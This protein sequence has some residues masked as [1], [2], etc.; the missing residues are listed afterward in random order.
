MKVINDRY[1]IFIF[2]F[3]IALGVDSLLTVIWSTYTARQYIRLLS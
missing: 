2:H 3:K 1:T